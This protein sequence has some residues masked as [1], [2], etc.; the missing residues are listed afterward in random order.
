[1]EQRSLFEED[2]QLATLA[3]FNTLE[4][5]KEWVDWDRFN[6]IL[7]EVFGSPHLRGPGRPVWD[8]MMMFR[9]IVLGIMYSLSDR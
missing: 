4:R 2:R 1:M 3:E 6:P 5:I 9:A 7:E 8:H